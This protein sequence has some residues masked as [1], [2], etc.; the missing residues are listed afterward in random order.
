MH[1]EKP[2][3]CQS[4]A[5]IAIVHRRFCVHE[6]G[7]NSLSMTYKRSD[8]VELARKSVTRRMVPDLLASVQDHGFIS[9]QNGRPLCDR[10]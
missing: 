3:E 10:P 6:T 4:D 1:F 9:R 8:Q 7:I 2:K 5:L